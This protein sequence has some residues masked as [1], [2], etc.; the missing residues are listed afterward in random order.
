MDVGTAPEPARDHESC[1]TSDYDEAIDIIT[2]VYVPHR[3]VLPTRSLNL[4]LTW[5]PLRHLVLGHLTYGAESHLIAPKLETFYHVNLTVSGRTRSTRGPEQVYTD[6]TTG[7][8]FLPSQPASVFWSEDCR[9][10]AMKLDKNGL[11]RELEKLLARPVRT[12][13]EFKLALDLLDPAIQ[14]F[15]RA[16]RFLRDELQHQLGIGANSL[17]LDRLEGLVMTSLLLAQ[18]SNYSDELHRTARPAHPRAI[19]RVVQMMEEEPHVHRTLGDFAEAAGLSVRALQDGF[20]RHLD[21]T[22]M[23]YLREVRLLRVRADL[24]AANPHEAT[25]SSVIG[26]WGFTH[27]GRFAGSYRARFGEL[28]SETLKRH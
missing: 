28:P 1:Q 27:I 20:H 8:V 24:Q 2:K 4:K 21:S 11:E 5:T 9:Q 15:V 14:G 16:L 23:G 19:S 7:L 10:L 12:P 17:G 3:L 26:R 25:V 22:P 13:I 6:A 18:P